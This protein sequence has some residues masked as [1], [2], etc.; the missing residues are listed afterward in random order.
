MPIET[1][2]GEHCYSHA[3]HQ[4]KSAIHKRLFPRSKSVEVK[5]RRQHGVAVVIGDDGSH[6]VVQE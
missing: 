2:Q 6:A 4:I 1:C 3:L 5:P